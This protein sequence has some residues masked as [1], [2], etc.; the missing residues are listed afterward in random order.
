M[1]YWKVESLSLCRCSLFSPFSPEKKEETKVAT[2]NINIH[3]INIKKN[4]I[5]IA[6]FKTKKQNAFKGKI[7]MVKTMVKTFE[8]TDTQH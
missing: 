1:C 6:L 4:V 3:N 7:K 2:I 8:N 5:N